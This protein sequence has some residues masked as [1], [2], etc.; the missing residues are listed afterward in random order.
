MKLNRL[1]ASA[2]LLGIV[3][4]TAAGLKAPTQAAPLT[5]GSNSLELAQRIGERPGDTCR[6]VRG[7]NVLYT[8]PDMNSTEIANM[9][10]NEQVN[11][12]RNAFVG[13]DGGM[14]FELE[15]S[16]GNIGFMPA[17][18]RMSPGGPLE[19]TLANCPGQGPSAFPVTW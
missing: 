9:L 19:S 17:Q 1:S 10:P 7:A 2:A 3:S 16:V 5:E 12:I 11:M 15:D 13:D 6:R 4:L 18:A 8:E 14:W